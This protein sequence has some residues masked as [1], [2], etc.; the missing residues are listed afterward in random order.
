MFL[1]L[2]HICPN[3]NNE[4]KRKRLELNTSNKKL[5]KLDFDYFPQ[6]IYS[7]LNT[8]VISN[9]KTQISRPKKVII[10]RKLT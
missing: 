5:F 8:K 10:K 3:K 7:K 1:T 9:L 4:M 2:N 6:S